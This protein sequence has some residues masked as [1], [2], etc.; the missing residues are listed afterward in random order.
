ME[1]LA[2]RWRI[3]V[4]QGGSYA[5][6]K[7]L[8]AVVCAQKTL[9]HYLAEA[10]YPKD[11]HGSVPQAVAA[12]FSALG[13]RE[14]HLLAG[15]IA[16]RNNISHDGHWIPGDMAVIPTPETT[17]AAVAAFRDAV[18]AIASAAGLPDP[19]PVDGAPLGP[20]VDTG[21]AASTSPSNVD[22]DDIPGWSELRDAMHGHFLRYEEG[23]S[24]AMADIKRL[25]D[26]AGPQTLRN[27]AVEYVN[28]RTANPTLVSKLAFLRRYGISVDRPRP[29][30]PL[31][32]VVS[33]VVDL[34]ALKIPETFEDDEK[35]GQQPVAPLTPAER[36]AAVKAR[37]PNARMVGET[38]PVV[39]DAPD[40]PAVSQAAAERIAAIKARWP[41]ARMVGEPDPFI[42]EE[43]ARGAKSGSGSPSDPV[44]LIKLIFGLLILGIICCTGL[45][46]LLRWVLT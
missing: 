25:R 12:A 45:I 3:L 5:T 44:K 37:W 34:D 39:A 46:V 30:K 43:S 35:S 28:E 21:E 33:L 24:S 41:N 2:L 42:R 23:Q 8:Y 19:S 15:A 27:L 6:E 40:K 16:L 1:H 26:Q 29:T 18:A 17:I 31:E 10:G 38:N 4:E 9:E 14:P 36:I 22:P 32:Q 11:K 7:R 20:E 13:I